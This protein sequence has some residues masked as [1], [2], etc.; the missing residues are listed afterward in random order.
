MQ[1][2][3]EDISRKDPRLRDK[4]KAENQRENFMEAKGL[5][6]ERSK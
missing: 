2:H 3:E 1:E 5:G 4:L 6:P